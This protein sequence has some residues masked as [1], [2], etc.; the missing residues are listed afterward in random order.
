ML[1]ERSNLGISQRAFGMPRYVEKWLLPKGEMGRC[2]RRAFKYNQLIE[3]RFARGRCLV[4]GLVK[5][6]YVEKWLLAKGA[7]T[8]AT[9]AD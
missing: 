6:R 9:L 3:G 2:Y 4:T 5:T 1:A 8:E 7:K